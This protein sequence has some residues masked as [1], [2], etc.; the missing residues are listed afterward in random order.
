MLTS[1]TSLS[2]LRRRP[3]YGVECLQN[4]GLQV[5]G[6]QRIEKKQVA[7]DRVLA[8][9]V[10]DRLAR[11]SRLSTVS[12]TSS[13][14]RSSPAPW[15]SIRS[16]TSSRAATFESA[17]RHLVEFADQGAEL[18]H[19]FLEFFFASHATPFSG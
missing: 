16:W 11:Y 7:D 19:L 9:S 17:T 1:F 12:K 8:E 5:I 14:I 4:A 6:M 18:P 2:N 10:D 15:T 3:C 13:I